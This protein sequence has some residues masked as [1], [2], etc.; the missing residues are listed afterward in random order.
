MI[1]ELNKAAALARANLNESIARLN[2][3]EKQVG[4]DLAEL[5]L[6]NDSTSS[7]G[8]LRRMAAEIEGELRQA[9]SAAK[10]NQQL[11]ALLKSGQDDPGQLLATPGRLLESQPALR[12]LKDGLVDAQLHAAGLES[13]MSPLHPLVQSARQAE[14]E[15]GRQLHDELALAI[16]GV[17]GDLRLNTDRVATL[18]TQL[19]QTTE[20][21]G[22][23]AGL[24][25]AYAS[26]VAETASRTK[27]LERAEQNLAE[28][29]ATHASAKAASL[30]SC[31]DV[32]DAGIRPVSPSRAM[33]VLAGIAG[34]L[35]LGLGVVFLTVQ[36][37]PT[38]AA[39]LQVLNTSATQPNVVAHTAP[40]LFPA[41]AISESDMPVFPPNGNLSLKQALYKISCG[42]R[43]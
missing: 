20:R 8:A 9:R 27:L 5:R 28:A 37:A 21:L 7:D 32:P 22:R 34:G 29:H 26:Q 6:L 2:T 43:V 15:I 14:Q 12:R 23:L 19:A 39:A 11:L 1:E 31:I 36:A 13:R 38:E 18:E 16:R 24:R 33:I 30:L 35:L 42:S 17:E 3:I 25:A 41:A 10:A 4:S 40:P